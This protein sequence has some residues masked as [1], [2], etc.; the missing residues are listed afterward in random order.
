MSLQQQDLDGVVP[1]ETQLKVTSGAS[2]QEWRCEKCDF[3]V[4]R[5]PSQPIEY[6]HNTD[7]DHWIGRESFACPGGDE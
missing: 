7:C 6:G 2:A 5:S 1:P 4:T 3:R